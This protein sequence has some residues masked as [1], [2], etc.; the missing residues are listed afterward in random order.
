MGE[1][2]LEELKSL[3]TLCRLNEQLL[4]VTR[5]EISE[6]TRREETEQA[7]LEATLS[8]LF[9]KLD[10]VQEDMGRFREEI[11]IRVEKCREA[12]EKNLKANYVTKPELAAMTQKLTTRITWMGTI[13]TLAILV[14][15][16]LMPGVLS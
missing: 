14:A 9:S 10:E 6:R 12:T 7:H 1:P 13:I 3:E 16:F 11:D 4:R 8:R 5:E 2:N 15:K